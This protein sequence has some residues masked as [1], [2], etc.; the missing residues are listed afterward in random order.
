MKSCKN[1][2]L[3]KTKEQFFKDLEIIEKNFQFYYN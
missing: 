2:K 3:T 1:F